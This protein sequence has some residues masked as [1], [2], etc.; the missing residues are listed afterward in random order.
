MGAF[1]LNMHENPFSAGAQPQTLL[2]SLRR[3]PDPL[4]VWG[5]GHPSHS[6]SSPWRLWRLDLAYGASLHTW[7]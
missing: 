7:L 2:G 3:S 6:L 4:V 1:N 5:G